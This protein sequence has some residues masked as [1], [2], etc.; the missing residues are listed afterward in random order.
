MSKIMSAT[1]TGL[2]VAAGAV[3]MSWS[4]PA[5]ALQMVSCT[6]IHSCDLYGENCTDYLFCDDGSIWVGA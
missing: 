4:T 6:K 3:G 2:L 1:L 5:V